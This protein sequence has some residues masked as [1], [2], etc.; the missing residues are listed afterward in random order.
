MPPQEVLYLDLC[1]DGQHIVT[2]TTTL[3]CQQLPEKG[4]PWELVMFDD[5][6]KHGCLV[7]VT[8]EKPRPTMFLQQFLSRQLYATHAGIMFVVVKQNDTNVSRLCLTE[9]VREHVQQTL[10]VELGDPLGTVSVSGYFCRW[11]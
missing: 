11:P 4:P 6:D 10:I 8:L 3:R 9:N 1:H 5:N 7:A 2:H